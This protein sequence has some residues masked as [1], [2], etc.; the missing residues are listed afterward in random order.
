MD[1]DYFPEYDLLYTDPPWGE[2]MV[3]WFSNY[4]FKKTGVK[5][6]HTLND[7]LNQLGRLA[8]PQKPMVIEYEIKGYDK[9][10]NVMQDHGHTYYEAT[11]G[12]QSMGRPFILLIFNTKF[13]FDPESEGFTFVKDAVRKT[14]ANTVFDP[15]AGIGNTAKAVKA[16]GATYI[17]SEINSDRYAKLKAVLG[18]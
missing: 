17:G 10:I 2:R 11:E 5:P 4:Q 14:K 1:W 18:V 3:K 12:M 8:N 7:I 16:T 15:F 9:V 13:Q 6:T